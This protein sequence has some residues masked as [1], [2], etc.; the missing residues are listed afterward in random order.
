MT[1]AITTEMER[2]ATTAIF[3]LSVCRITLQQM[4][5]LIS[6]IKPDLK[7]NSHADRLLMM[8][9]AFIESVSSNAEAAE[10]ALEARFESAAPQNTDEDNRGANSR[11]DQ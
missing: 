8:A 3:E 9:A 2:I 7:T 1:R 11:A 4:E 5:S 6:V 10:E